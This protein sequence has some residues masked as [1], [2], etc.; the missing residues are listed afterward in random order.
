MLPR[1]LGLAAKVTVRLTMVSE[2]VGD[3]G[4]A[5]MLEL[6]YT[7]WRTL[8]PVNFE[9]FVFYDIGFVTNQDS[10]GQD[11]RSSLSSAG[12]GMRFATTG[13]DRDGGRSV[14]VDA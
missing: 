14:P 1:S 9:P 7:G 11:T 6:R 13:T 10:A 8:Q 2:I 4:A 12:V 5:G 3:R